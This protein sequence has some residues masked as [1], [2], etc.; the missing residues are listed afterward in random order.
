MVPAFFSGNGGLKMFWSLG[1]T[2]AWAAYGYLRTYHCFF[3]FQDNWAQILSNED[4]RL[5]TAA[6]LDEACWNE[7]KCSLATVTSVEFL[8]SGYRKWIP[9]IQLI[10]NELE[11]YGQENIRDNRKFPILLNYPTVI[12]NREVTKKISGINF[13]QPI[14]ACFLSSQDK[15][16]RNK[17]SED[18]I[19]RDRIEQ[20]QN[21]V[22]TKY[23]HNALPMP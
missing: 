5:S 22:R 14:S 23:Q 1:I 20:S 7:F 21:T 2:F 6:E 8:V 16:P 13:K 9:A 12:F 4:G 11:I 19:P 18:K 15:V 3:L 17:K 10:H